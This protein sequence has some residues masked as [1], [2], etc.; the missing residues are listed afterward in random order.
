MDLLLIGKRLQRNWTKFIKRIFDYLISNYKTIKTISAPYALISIFGII[1]HMIILE[2]LFP[3]LI[4]TFNYIIDLL[5]NKF[6]F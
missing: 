6:P 1:T 3:L 4:K 5:I 2:L